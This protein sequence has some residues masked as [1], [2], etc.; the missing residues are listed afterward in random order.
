MSHFS[1]TSKTDKKL[2][3]FLSTPHAITLLVISVSFIIYHS[4]NNPHNPYLSALIT[5][6]AIFNLIGCLQFTDSIFKRPIPIFWRIVKSSSIFYLICL[7]ILLYF[8]KEEVR[9]VLSFFDSSLNKPLP[10]KDYATACS[11]TFE[12][13]K[14]QMD[15]FVP[16]HI[17]G[18]FFKTL[19]IRDKFICW[20][21]SV[22]F[23]FCEYSLAHQLKNFNECWWDHWLLDV[24]IC[25]WAGIEMASYLIRKYNILQ[26]QF[27]RNCNSLK[28]YIAIIFL[29]FFI[30][31]AELNAFYLK[32]L[33]WLPT[34]HFFN[35]IRLIIFIPAGALAIRECYAYYITDEKRV[36]HMLWLAMAVVSLEAILVLK[37]AKN[38]F[39]TPFPSIVKTCWGIGFLL[40]IVIGV[41][42]WF[43]EQ[44]EKRKERKQKNK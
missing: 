42:I 17:F 41:F 6:F 15:I 10:E 38:E 27:I 30:L 7:V 28:R 3:N 33:L 43:N 31:I 11:L 2:L 21:L 36:R 18:W 16:L 25:N 23:E 32:A 14:N 22:L 19:I 29:I 12:N 40:I 5:S 35:S 4:F 26:Y 44:N 34:D 20:T 39:Q 1:R 8:E 13:I 37:F 24:L 9:F